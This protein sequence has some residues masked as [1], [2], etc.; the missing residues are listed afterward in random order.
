V[1]D[2]DGTVRRLGEE[3]LATGE[4]SP[5]LR[6]QLRSHVL[7]EQISAEGSADY[8]YDPA[9]L[10]RGLSLARLGQLAR[11][12]RERRADPGPLP[13]IAQAYAD[14]AARA[15]T[16]EARIE[17]LAISATMWSLAGY[18]A[19]ATAIA[20][21]FQQEVG[22]LFSYGD[23]PDT[24]AL[25]AAAP[26]R[27]AEAAGAVLRRDIDTTARLGAAAASE[28]PRLGRALTAQ[29]AAGNAEQA[30]L[31]V[32]AAYGL[33]GRSARSL[34]TLWRTGDRTAG[35]AAISDLKQAAAILLQ[36]SVVDTWTLVDSLAH[37]V[38]DIVATSPWLLLR[39]ASTWSRTWER[40]LKA[41]IVS[42]RPLTQVWP[43]QRTALDAGLLDTRAHNFTVT[44]PTSAGKTHIAEW[45]I[46]HALADTG[47][48]DDSPLGLLLRFMDPP[49]AVY[50]VPTRALA[51]Q[52]ERHLAASLELVGLRVSSLFGGAEHVRYENQLLDYTDVLVVT[53]EKLDL[54][55]R[56]T[57]ELAGRLRLVLVDEGH[58]IDRSARGLR[59]EMV[60]TRIRRTTPQARIVLLSAVLPNGEDIAR[61]LEPTADGT[62]HAK[63][64]WS[65]SQLRTGIFCWQGQEKDGQTGNIHYGT[66]QG[67]DFFVP[68][69]LTRHL[70]RSRLSPRATKDVA[71]ALALH[72]ERLGPVLISTT[73]PA[74]A[75]AAAR[76]LQTAL[77]KTDTPVLGVRN[78]QDQRLALSERIAEHLGE[79]HELTVMV[80]QGIAYH[81]GTVPQSVRHL[82]ERAYRDG[83]LRVLC[84][85]STLSQ[86]MN[87]PV[88]TVLVHSTWRNQEQMGVREFWNA[89]GRAGRAFQETEGHVVL[90]AK[91]AED[92]RKLRRRYLDKGN[93]E[94]V[95][96]TIGALYH[97]L[98]ITRLGARPAPGQNLTDIE[99]P[100]PEEGELTDWAQALDLQLL[101][102]LAEEVVDTPDQQL[103]E[104]AAHDLLAHTLGGHQIGAQEWSLKPL[105][106]FTARR[107]AALARQLPDPA[108]RAAILRTGLSLQG[109]L[110]AIIAAEQLANTFT[111][112]PGLLAPATW[113][114]LRDIVLTAATTIQE[115]RRSATAKD[116]PIGAVV[117][118]AGDWIAGWTLQEI[119]SHYEL[120]L[121]AKDITVTSDYID[122]VIVQDLA[123]AVSSILQILETRH[124]ITPEGLLAALPAMLKY[125]VDT[126][127]ACYAASLGIHQR[128]EA[129]DLAARCPVLEPSFSDFTGWLG[130][131]TTD[132]ITAITTPSTASLLI[133]SAERRSPRTVQKTILSGRGTFTTPLRGVRHTY[134]D[135]YLADL[136]A[137]TVLD[138]VRDY[139]NPTDPNAIRV[140]H[141]GLPL[142]WI[143]KGTARP[144]ALAL[145]DRP[146][147]LVT[148]IL[149]TD[150]RSLADTAGTDQL[151][152]YDQIDLTIT[153]SP[154]A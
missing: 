57:P 62:N 82:L 104:D 85:T 42:D 150:T 99:L 22:N 59:L 44:M 112:H 154:R 21:T 6:K 141:N 23:M 48:A 149:H 88:K 102:M 4:A 10:R 65:P 29:L 79:D 108:A 80:T 76:A 24:D 3:A 69:V 119:H 36:A 78:Q 7:A 43:S 63:I 93:I 101:T 103:L 129:I 53:T 90:I 89:A 147:P 127:P 115:L 131:L 14:L 50:V 83:A 98:A 30:D 20:H 72:F 151:A 95:L 97:R 13:D 1:R 91:D 31:A 56:N 117:P 8:T 25:T 124:G 135:G 148:A 64:D 92:A 96:S 107:V 39:R 37:A 2:D 70:T 111:E 67:R 75:Q 142:G 134:S 11:T 128:S 27:I 45:A 32:L 145:D 12:P 133:R 71:A 61:W 87:L 140:E 121:D 47:E 41:L 114:A 51:A 15:N 35:R 58:S 16:P 84:A 153:I 110:D 46:L 81:H 116:R 120:L 94:P 136:P 152:G 125:G 9:A 123:W 77:Q 17:L 73:Q 144:L 49:L 18:Q 86:G 113:P 130:N 34:A 139:D 26:F 66:A 28:L 143:A 106:R 68:K 33:V 5:V 118:L 60:L 19:N 137:G 109:G 55:L 74:Y 122:K 54:L 126:A 38:E 100:D 52:V 138:L 40:Y 132:E 105:A 146:A